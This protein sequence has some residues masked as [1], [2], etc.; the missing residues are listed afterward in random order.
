M[1]HQLTLLH[2]SPIPQ[3]A[4]GL[5]KVPADEDGVSIILEAIKASLLLLFID[6]E[7]CISNT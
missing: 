4:F 6:V 5:Y 3:L 7:W 1:E 2:G